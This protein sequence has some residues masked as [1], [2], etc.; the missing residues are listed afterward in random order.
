M[1]EWLIITLGG[2]LGSRALFAV[3]AALWSGWRGRC[4][5][6]LCIR[7]GRIEVKGT[8][9]KTCVRHAR[10]EIHEQLRRE[11]I[12]VKGRGWVTYE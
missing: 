8:L 9:W 10:W 11:H 7:P 1:R 6:S 3:A 5:V 2:L 4:H 12:K